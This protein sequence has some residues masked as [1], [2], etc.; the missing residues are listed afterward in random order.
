MKVANTEPNVRVITR[1]VGLG[2]K[3]VGLGITCL[4]YCVGPGIKICY[5][6]GIRDIKGFGT[7]NRITD[8]K[9]YLVTT[10]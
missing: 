5:A 6:F 10:L 7:K 3:G 9:I 8:E 1:C 4:A 2:I